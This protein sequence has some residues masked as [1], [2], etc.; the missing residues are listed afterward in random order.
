MTLTPD[1][2]PGKCHRRS[3]GTAAGESAEGPQEPGTAVGESAADEDESL[4]MPEPTSFREQLEAAG[5]DLTGNPLAEKLDSIAA[6]PVTPMESCDDDSDRH[7]T[8]GAY[9][10]E[11]VAPVDSGAQSDGG[12]IDR[13]PT[14]DE[15]QSTSVVMH[16][17]LSDAEWRDLDRLAPELTRSIGNLSILK[18]ELLRFERPL[19]PDHA[20][21]VINGIETA[22]R[23]LEAMSAVA[24]SV[25]E[26][27]GTPTDYGAKTTK[28]LVQN[29]LNLTG[30]EANR[31]AELAKNLGGRVYMTGQ[32]REPVNPIVSKALHSGVLSAGQATAINDCLSKLP[33][34][35]SSSVRDKVEADLVER[36]PR[37]RVSDLKTIFATILDRIDPDG[38]EPKLSRDRSR[39]YVTV[40]ARDDGDWDL[41]G[42][43]DSVS[44][45]ILNGLLASRILPGDNSENPQSAPGSTEP[46]QAHDGAR[47]TDGTRTTVKDEGPAEPEFDIFRAVL[48]GDVSDAPLPHAL[49]EDRPDWIADSGG[50]DSAVSGF[51]S[52][53]VSEDGAL[54]DTS[55]S[56]GTVRNR[57]Y[58]RFATMISRVEMDRIGRGSPF[59][60]VVTAKAED[61]ATGKGR[62]TTGC[63][64]EFPL[65]TAVS[66]GLNGSVFFHLMSDKAKTMEIATEGRYATNRQVAV[67]A[68]RDQGCTFPG[69]DA[70]PGWCD[71]HHIVPWA[72]GGKTDINNLTLACGLHH[73][74][75]DKS[76]WYARMLHDGRPAWIP[77]LGIDV[78]RRPIL[79]ARFVAQEIID[80]LFDGAELPPQ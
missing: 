19:G 65:S 67:L 5:M 9:A 17:L 72:D 39:C 74:L 14:A 29:R 4:S 35:V 75:I 7:S 66:E 22:T 34:W 60:L 36:A 49:P 53:G 21:T 23:I 16:P 45:G 52:F 79:H 15:G 70:P 12:G 64:A 73:H 51:S 13:S 57:I 41:R 43:L 42:L 44:G 20:M 37:V 24:L 76:D 48:A 40:R 3:P 30:Y 54:V 77:P 58:G 27:C 50:S 78:E 55:G 18:D 62:S 6:V 26:R 1:R 71:A 59:A 80:G 31:R 63:E 10:D 61:I 38:E 8:E 32:A 25:Y 46:L 69:C 68:A 33:I 47:T 28:A 56:Q 11:Q 2:T